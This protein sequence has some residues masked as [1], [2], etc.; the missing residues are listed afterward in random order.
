MHLAPVAAFVYNRPAHARRVFEALQRNSLAT[1]SDLIVFAD[2]PGATDAVA[3]VREVREYI[4]T[5]KGFKSIRFVER[6]ANAGLARSIIDGVTDV[7]AEFGRVI[8]LEDDL[9]TSPW[10]LKYMNDG[11]DLYAEDDRVASIHGYRYPAKAVLPETFFLRGADCWGWATWDRA[12]RHFE[13]DGGVLL[14]RLESQGL[15]HEFDL[16][17]AFGFTQMLRDQIARRNDSWAVRWHA[18]CFL[19]NRLTLYPGRSLVENIGNDASGT[20]RGN[21]SL[22]DAPVSDSPIDVTRIPLEPSDVGRAAFRQFLGGA[23]QGALLRRVL[24]KVA[25]G[26]GLRS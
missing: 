15:E 8:V 17:G 11:L 2:G 14:E 20:H 13:P 18:S 5:L 12:W 23:P 9:V 16:G 4:R 7:C 24:A 22:Y 25:R 6:D 1:E 19:D 21:T 10:F 26:L 3:A